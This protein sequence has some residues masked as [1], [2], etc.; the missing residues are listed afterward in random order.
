MLGLEAPSQ[1][2]SFEEDFYGLSDGDSA[3]SLDS[4]SSFGGDLD[5]SMRGSL[6]VSGLKRKFDAFAPGGMRPSGKPMNSYYYRPSQYVGWPNTLFP[7]LAPVPVE[8]VEKKPER[9]WPAE[10]KRLAES[11]LRVESLRS[12]TGGLRIER[13]LESYD[14]R[15]DELVSQSAD[16]A[17]G[18][19]GRLAQSLG[20][21]GTQ[22]IVNW[23][24][25]NERGVFSRAFELGR[26]RASV[27]LDREQWPGSFGPHMLTSIERSYQDHTVTLQPQDE[28]R[29]LLS[30]VHPNNANREIR[31]L[32][33]TARGVVLRTESSQ[34]GKLQ[35][36]SECSQFVELLDRWWPTRIEGTD[37]EGRRT[38]LTTLDYRTLEADAV[39]PSDGPGAGRARSGGLSP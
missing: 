7:A 19:V 17:P 29:T 2:W 38:S 28:G 8:P 26:V 21:D 20:G 6:A 22:T 4:A 16:L 3:V 33:D 15:W 32:I 24:D 18:V 36:A 11:L 27:P 1:P 34:D 37:G 10:A 5:K 31:I 13:Q 9:P 39:R 30:L 35:W 23:L 12:M 25:E 14:A